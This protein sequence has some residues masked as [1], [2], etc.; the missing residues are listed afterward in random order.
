MKNMQRTN[1]QAQSGPQLIFPFAA[2]SS[3]KLVRAVLYLGLLGLGFYFLR[4]GD[5]TSLLEFRNQQV[6]PLQNRAFNSATAFAF[7]ALGFLGLLNL[8]RARALPNAVVITPDTVHATHQGLM[9][10]YVTLH[11]PELVRLHKV[12]VDGHWELS[13]EGNRRKIRVT[14]A[15]LAQPSDFE[16]LIQSLQQRAPHC[17]LEVVERVNPPPAR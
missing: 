13:I 1:P 16:S 14:Q 6:S 8:W 11:L 3:D 4:T 17:T 10:R 9:G 2:F 5:H 12:S 7:G 15:A